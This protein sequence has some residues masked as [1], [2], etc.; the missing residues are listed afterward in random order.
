MGSQSD[1]AMHNLASAFGMAQVFIL[2][3]FMS[4]YTGPT[5]S[6]YTAYLMNATDTQHAMEI[7]VDT[8]SSSPLY[9]L[10]SFVTCVFAL[11]TRRIKPDANAPY[12]IES[13]RELS[14]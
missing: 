9:L 10:T 8:F 1:D 14:P 2:L 12:T 7:D 4:N 6:I 13:I 3:I 11:T 5:L